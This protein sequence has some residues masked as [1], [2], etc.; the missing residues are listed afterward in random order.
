MIEANYNPQMMRVKN[1]WYK[2]EENNVIKSMY[3]PSHEGFK[4][5]EDLDKLAKEAV[6]ENEDWFEWIFL[7]CQNNKRRQAHASKLLLGI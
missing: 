5:N 7:S 1:V 3:V 4:P 2:V 6:I